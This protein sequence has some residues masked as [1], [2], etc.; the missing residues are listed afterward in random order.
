MC[1]HFSFKEVDQSEMIG[2]NLKLTIEMSVFLVYKE[3]EPKCIGSLLN[4]YCN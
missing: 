4:E 2:Y 1:K 3:L